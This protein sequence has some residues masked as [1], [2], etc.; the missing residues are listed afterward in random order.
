MSD[1]YFEINPS[2][3]KII[4]FPVE[5]DINWNNISGITFLSK[6]EL[7]DLSWAGYENI[8]FVKLSKENKNIIENFLYDSDILDKSK[9]KYRLIVTKNCSEKEMSPIMVDDWFSIQLTEKNKLR[10]LMKYNECIL[11]RNLKFNWKTLSGF[12]ELNSEKFIS[13]YDKIQIYI[14]KLIDIEYELYEKIE[15]CKTISELLDMDLTI[16][17][18]PEIK[19]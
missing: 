6:E 10:F 19:L 3:N 15:N 2:E 4:N 7:Y 17:F 9:L 11:N 5:L 8:G 18:I 12:V 14:Q 16:D 1:F 13:L